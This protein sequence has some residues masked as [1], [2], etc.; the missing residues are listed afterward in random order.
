MTACKN[1]EE[2]FLSFFSPSVS[3]RT[4]DHFYFRVLLSLSPAF[5]SKSDEEGHLL[6]MK[7]VQEQ[8]EVRVE[9]GS[10]FQR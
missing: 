3:L 4:T 1:G 2:S 9:M 6:R 7:M 8:A 10:L 5:L